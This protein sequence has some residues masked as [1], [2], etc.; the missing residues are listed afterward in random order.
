MSDNE[1]NPQET[2]IGKIDKKD[3]DILNN[4]FTNL[5]LSDSNS[6]LS[7]EDKL[8]ESDWNDLFEDLPKMKN[9]NEGEICEIAVIKKIFE[10]ITNKD[11]KQLEKIFGKDAEKNIILYNS[12]KVE[13]K[14]VNQITKA[15]AGTK[16]D[17]IIKF[18]KTESYINI[19]IKSKY[20]S[21]PA[22]LNHTCR[23]AVV[24][25]VNGDLFDELKILDE[26]VKIMNTKRINKEVSEDIKI[27]NLKLNDTQKSCLMNVIKYFIFEGTGSKKSISPANAILDIYNL[28]N[29]NEWKFMLCNTN[30]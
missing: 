21:P 19:S 27:N 25:C 13:I 7:P 1:T 12:L 17:F 30:E 22:I 6:E 20:A 8:P 10:L 28:S 4:L 3:D 24:F 18:I 5:N 23:S 29:I 14:N 26:I 9:K 2:L 11:I 16:A 15:P